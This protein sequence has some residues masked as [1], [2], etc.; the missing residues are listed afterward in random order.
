MR[1]SEA[2]LLP[3]A[4]G[5]DVLKAVDD[6]IILLSVSRVFIVGDFYCVPPVVGRAVPL[7]LHWCRVAFTIRGY[8]SARPARN[9]IPKSSQVIE[10][11]MSKPRKDR[12][13]AYADHL[14]DSLIEEVGE[15]KFFHRCSHLIGDKASVKNES[16]ISRKTFVNGRSSQRMRESV[17]RGIEIEFDLG[18]NYFAPPAAGVERLSTHF[19]DLQ[20]L[21]GWLGNDTYGLNY[22]GLSNHG[23]IN[24]TDFVEVQELLEKHLRFVGT[25]EFTPFDSFSLVEMAI[26]FSTH[27]LVTSPVDDFAEQSNRLIELARGG[28]DR[29]MTR[30]RANTEWI[31]KLILLRGQLTRRL[32][33]GSE[34]VWSKDHP[35][36]SNALAKARFHRLAALNF[37]AGHSLAIEDLEDESLALQIFEMIV[38]ERMGMARIASK[39]ASQDGMKIAAKQFAWFHEQRESLE[40]VKNT[41]RFLIDVRWDLVRAIWEFRRGEKLVAMRIL[42]RCFENF[43]SSS[44]TQRHDLYQVLVLLQFSFGCQPFARS[45]VDVVSRTDSRLEVA[46]V[47]FDK[48]PLRSHCFVELPLIRQMIENGR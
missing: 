46:R 2:E 25:N 45:G 22:T 12:R 44:M 29:M 36:A 8:V 47:H 38:H 21:Q 15:A 11:R 28:V 9:G 16:E 42:T 30:R 20:S 19:Q 31:A 40:Q 23:V 41:N 17:L 37:E 35:N 4:V 39:S 7:N 3:V 48:S 26:E 27:R 13:S 24:P 5:G 14:L 34:P 18:S 33:P 10:N 1:S 43:E 32:I 6:L